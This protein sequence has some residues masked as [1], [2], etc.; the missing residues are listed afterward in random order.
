MPANAGNT[1]SSARKVRKQTTRKGSGVTKRK[2]T[3]R[4]PKPKFTDGQQRELKRGR[5][6]EER[7]RRKE[8]GLCRDCKNLA[9]P[10]KTRC[11]DCAE[12]HSKRQR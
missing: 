8:L 2:S 3:V 7:Q 12:K 1:K 9:V 6:A 10:G 11:P 5:S 4:A